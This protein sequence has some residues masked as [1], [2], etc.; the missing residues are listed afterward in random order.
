MENRRQKVVRYISGSRAELQYPPMDAKQL[1]MTID[2][3]ITRLRRIADEH[4]DECYQMAMDNHATRSP[5]L[6]KELIDAWGVIR[7]RP[8]YN[9]HSGEKRERLCR[10]NCSADGWVTVDADG[11]LYVSL[12]EDDQY[13]TRKEYLY[14]KA[15]PDHRPAGIPQAPHAA[16]QCPGEW[17]R[18]RSRPGAERP[19]SGKPKAVGGWK[20]LGDVAEQIAPTFET[21][22]PPPDNF[23]GW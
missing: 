4:L 9:S 1:E 23:L 17:P 11:N 12:S 2:Q 5:L 19:P 8:G 10:W 13:G 6:P 22:E 16:P 15:C 7:Q 14:V 18:L 21:P 20:S 3:W